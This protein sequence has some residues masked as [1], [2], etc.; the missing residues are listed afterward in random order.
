MRAGIAASIGLCILGTFVV[1]NL[2]AV[3]AEGRYEQSLGADPFRLFR[4]PGPD[5]GCSDGIENANP[6]ALTVPTTCPNG[7]LTYGQSRTTSVPV[8]TYCFTQPT[9][10]DSSSKYYYKIEYGPT[11]GGNWITNAQK[12][13]AW[14]ASGFAIRIWYNRTMVVEKIKPAGSVTAPINTSFYGLSGK[15]YYIQ[16]GILYSNGNFCSM[17]AI[18]WT[19][20]TSMTSLG[21]R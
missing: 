2:P 7:T 8:A 5:D 3:A 11:S 10:D 9:Y 13:A 18:P 17:C 19:V 6:L 21:K 14:T 20:T 4:A 15:K 16:A 1:A 12:L